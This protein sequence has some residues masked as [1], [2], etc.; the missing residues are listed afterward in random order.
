MFRGFCV[1]EEGVGV[2]KRGKCGKMRCIVVKEKRKIHA[3][4]KD[5]IT[6]PKLSTKGVRFPQKS[7]SFPRIYVTLRLCKVTVAQIALV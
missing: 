3:L 2:K 5:D 6:K 1:E 7:M 4:E